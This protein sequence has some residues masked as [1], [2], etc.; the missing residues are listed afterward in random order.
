MNSPR[1]TDSNAGSTAEGDVQRYTYRN[2]VVEIPTGYLAVGLIVAPHGL[3]GEMRVEL[4]TDYPDRFTPGLELFFGQALTPITVRSS[5]PHKGHLLIHF[6]DVYNREDAE[7]LRNQWLFVAEEDAMGLEEGIY[8]IHDLIGLTVLT[9]EGE[10][11]GTITDVLFT[12][13]NE[14]YVVKP[15]ATSGRSKDIL[16][17]AIADVVQT[18][19]LEEGVLTV[20]VPEGLLDL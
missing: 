8:Y 14:V 4:H 2:R 6:E 10:T 15:V 9:T 18:V 1:K 11:L 16:I 3:K 12:G 17:P 7:A 13:A 19:D 20:E 5:R